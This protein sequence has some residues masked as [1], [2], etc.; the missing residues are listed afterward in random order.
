MKTCQV[1]CLGGGQRQV[2][3]EDTGGRDEPEAVLWVAG[4]MMLISFRVEGVSP[5]CDN[6]LPCDSKS[7]L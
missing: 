5:Y 6:D 3:H 1:L 4:M 7:V 2:A